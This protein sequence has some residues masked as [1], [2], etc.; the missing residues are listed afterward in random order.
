MSKESQKRIEARRLERIRRENKEKLDSNTAPFSIP[1]IFKDVEWGDYNSSKYPKKFVVD[2]KKLAS[3]KTSFFLFGSF[4]SGKSRFLH[5]FA[6]HLYLELGFRQVK[7]IRYSDMM[8]LVGMEY[9]KFTETDEFKECKE[10]SVLLVDD[11]RK[12]EGRSHHEYDAF[13]DLLD[14]RIENG[15]TTC[16]TSNLPPTKIS[17]DNGRITSR[18]TRILGSKK[19]VIIF[20]ESFVG[21]L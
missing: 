19:N 8:K 7:L 14:A 18:F 20:R 9:G 21:E 2:M 13:V 12:I 17:E 10:C 4:G 3:D 15:L 11:I 5:L 16:F 6:K 1:K